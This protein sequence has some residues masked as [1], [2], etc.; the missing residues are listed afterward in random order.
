MKDSQKLRVV[1]DRVHFYTTAKQIRYGVGDDYSCNSAVQKCLLV[2]E[3]MRGNG[4]TPVG[5]SGIWDGHQ[6]QLDI[7]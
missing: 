2:L 6:V 1:M 4:N 3:T 7:Q 5:L